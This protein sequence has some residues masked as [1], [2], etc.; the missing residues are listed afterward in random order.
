MRV[1][2]VCPVPI[3]SRTGVPAAI[4]EE[5]TDPSVFPQLGGDPAR[6][7]IIAAGCVIV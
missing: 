6:F 7:T 4:T 2:V 1:F 3:H 5:V